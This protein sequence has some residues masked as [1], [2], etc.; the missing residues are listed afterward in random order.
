[1]LRVLS[2]ECFLSERGLG[3]AMLNDR[4]WLLDIIGLFALL[5]SKLPSW[6]EA[7]EEAEWLL[8]LNRF[9]STLRMSAFPVPELAGRRADNCCLRRSRPLVG[10][11]AAEVESWLIAC[12]SFELLIV[13]GEGGLVAAKEWKVRGATLDSSGGLGT[14]AVVELW[15]MS[16]RILEICCDCC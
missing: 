1:M 15:P 10:L 14:V 11:W 7:F 16:A 5:C 8:C 9:V 3:I 6:L 12:K 2:E 13:G 4:C